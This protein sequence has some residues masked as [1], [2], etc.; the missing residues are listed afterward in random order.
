MKT[1]STVT[2]FFLM[3]LL[4]WQSC[5]GQS[6]QDNAN[7]A[8]VWAYDMDEPIAI[9]EMK[10]ILREISGL[11][12]VPGKNLLAVVQDEEGDIFLLDK[13]TGEIVGQHDFDKDGDYEGV[14]A[15]KDCIFVVK[16]SGTLFEVQRVGKKNQKTIKFNDFLNSDYDVEGLAFDEKNHRLLLACKAKAGE[17][18]EF[19]FKKA[20]YAFDLNTNKM[21]PVPAV[22][23]GIEDIQ[24]YL[25][26]SP[27][28]RKLEKIMEYFSPNQS[29]FIFSPS[30]IAVHPQTGNYYILSTAGKILVIVNP[31]GKILHIQKLKKKTHRQPE[32]ICF[33]LDGTL[34][35]SNEGDGGK[36]RIYKY[37]PIRQ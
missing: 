35:I 25:D 7:T 2:G 16:S 1:L 33:D 23:I 11:S 31:Q 32:G 17:G 18:A 21:E 36:G 24:D 12:V 29:K 8:F 34:Y 14:E 6:G 30:G 9:F 28:I 19:D 27:G 26:T 15:V 10:N 4:C 37:S 20:I 5:Q 3:T 22:V 13:N